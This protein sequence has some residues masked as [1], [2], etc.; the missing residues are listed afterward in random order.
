MFSDDSAARYY[1]VVIMQ[2]C[3]CILNRYY[4]KCRFV[5]RLRI[6]LW[7]YAGKRVKVGKLP[8]VM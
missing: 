3:E 8:R 1:E 6:P 2:L 7:R 4:A 5:E